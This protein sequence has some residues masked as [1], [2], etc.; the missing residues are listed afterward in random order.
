MIDETCKA[1]SITLKRSLLL[2]KTKNYQII[3]RER[4]KYQRKYGNHRQ[5]VN[6]S[7][8]AQELILVATL[9]IRQLP[10]DDLVLT[11]THWIPMLCLKHDI[12]DVMLQMSLQMSD[13]RCRAIDVGSQ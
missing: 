9:N 4:L 5:S 3:R 6:N 8:L 12:T 2:N 1:P 13:H 10:S 11:V 7:H